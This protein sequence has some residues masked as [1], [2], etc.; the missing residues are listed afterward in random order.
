MHHIVVESCLFQRLLYTSFIWGI[1]VHTLV[2]VGTVDLKKSKDEKS[3]IWV[4]QR[5]SGT[6]SGGAYI[7]LIMYG[8]HYR[9]R[10][11]FNSSVVLMS[12]GASAEGEHGY[13]Y[14]IDNYCW[15]YVLYFF[16]QG[17]VTACLGC[18]TMLGMDNVICLLYHVSP[19]GWE[20][21]LWSLWW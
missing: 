4:C 7:F 18:P 12:G 21:Y 5:P 19:L 1:C 3:P 15:Y 11:W 6:G 20:S 16:C 2:Y 8:W 14:M 17:H 9:R 13:W 10:Y